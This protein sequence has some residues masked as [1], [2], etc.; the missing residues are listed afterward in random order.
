MKKLFIV[1]CLF[2]ALFVNCRGKNAAQGYNSEIHGELYTEKDAGFSMY[3]PKGWEIKDMYQKYLMAMGPI[4][5]GFTP[6][7]VFVF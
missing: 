4:D 2:S 1:F 5:N 7:I 3:I 6:N